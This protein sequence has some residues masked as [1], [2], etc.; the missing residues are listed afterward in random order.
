MGL[1]NIVMGSRTFH[2][3]IFLKNAADTDDTKRFY[4]FN[5]NKKFA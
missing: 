3:I 4:H 5:N 2:H 1:G